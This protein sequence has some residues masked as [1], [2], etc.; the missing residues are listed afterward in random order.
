MSLIIDGMDQQHCKIPHLGTQNS[1]NSPIHQL[2][3]GAK[4]HDDSLVTLYRC[5]GT[6]S[7]GANLAIY[8]ILDQIVQWE[9][10]HGISP[11]ILYVQLD[12]GSENANKWVLMVLE[13]LVI[14]RVVRVAYFNRLPVGH[15]HADIDA[16]FGNIWKAFRGNPCLTVED[17]TRIIMEAF[18]SQEETGLKVKVKDVSVVPNFQAVVEGCVDAN[19]SKLH[20]EEY[21]QHQ[22]R[23]EAVT[24]SSD[25]P[26]GCKVTY[27]AYSSDY[28][29]ELRH[30]SSTFECL[31]EV[32]QYTELEPV[33]VY[34]QW[35]PTSKCDFSRPGVEGFY[36]VR[37][38]PDWQ[39]SFPNRALFPAQ[40]LPENCV[41]DIAN[42][43]AEVN[44]RFSSLDTLHVKESWNA[45]KA[46]YAPTSQDIDEYITRQ[47]RRFLKAY[48]RPLCEVLFRVLTT[49]S[50]FGFYDINRW[51]ALPML[52]NTLTSS[53]TRDDAIPP[54]VLALASHSVQSDFNPSPFPPR[55][56]LYR[57]SQLA[58]GVNEFKSAVK[59]Y[60]TTELK[61]LT[62]P[63]LVSILKRKVTIFGAVAPTSGTKHAQCDRICKDDAE[64]FTTVIRRLNPALSHFVTNLTRQGIRRVPTRI[65]QEIDSAVFSIGE[66]FQLGRKTFIQFG[67]DAVLKREG[68]EAALRLFAYRDYQIF[69]RRRQD[70]PNDNTL[71]KPSYF[72]YAQNVQQ[73]VVAPGLASNNCPQSTLNMTFAPFCN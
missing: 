7:K 61:R 66:T 41:R 24:P 36:L 3:M 39:T 65:E 64:L 5:F 9:G 46:D 30:R 53:D 32:G 63:E 68:V 2:I 35:Y 71:L 73:L 51:A 1:F 12:G 67:E 69:E 26:F 55:L 15:T 31:S 6:V 13:L 8:C 54:D 62:Q 22:F 56:Y 18:T 49:K 72:C 4:C 50:S 58:L 28:A 60:Y 45:W 44:S 27:R 11:E 10:R 57:D 29:I 21:T 40:A 19:L 59:S 42:T 43:V 20:K 17:Y 70:E 16:I 14:K 52:N 37:K 38:L 34:C 47:R 48:E 23:F 25:F 33:G